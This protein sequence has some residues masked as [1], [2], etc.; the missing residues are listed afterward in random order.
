MPQK[1]NNDISKEPRE[2][3]VGEGIADFKKKGE[4]EHKLPEYEKL[5]PGELHHE[6]RRKGIRNYKTMDKNELI[7]KLKEKQLED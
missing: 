1:E 2:E 4:P 5:E 6:A 7:K 3:F